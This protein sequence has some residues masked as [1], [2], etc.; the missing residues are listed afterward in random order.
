M[1][2]IECYNFP[3]QHIDIDSQID[4]IDVDLSDVNILTPDTEKQMRD[5]SDSTQLDYEGFKEEVWIM[6][7]ISK[8]KIY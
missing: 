3:F 2:N 5:F 6:V 7:L 8:Y 1:S 4:S